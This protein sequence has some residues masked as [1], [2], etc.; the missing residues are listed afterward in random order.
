M[1]VYLPD[2]LYE[3]VKVRGL[4][5]SAEIGGFLCRHSP[6]TGAPPSRDQFVGRSHHPSVRDDAGVRIVDCGSVGLN[7]RGLDRASFAFYDSSTGDVRLGEVTYPTDRLL[8]EVEARGYPAE[9]VD[10]YRRRSRAS[11]RI[12]G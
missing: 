7:R 4:P 12:A 6:G 11:R 9:C 2:D 5:A 10:Y 3:Q 8:R 1:Q